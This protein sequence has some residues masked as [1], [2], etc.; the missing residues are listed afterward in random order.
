MERIT[1]RDKFLNFI[2]FVKKN[3]K[4]NNRV[5]DVSK[6]LPNGI[7]ARVI[8]LINNSTDNKFIID[9]VFIVSNNYN[10]Y[11]LT[12]DILG[13]DYYY[14][15]NYYL[16]ISEIKKGNKEYIKE[17]AK[18]NYPALVSNRQVFIFAMKILG[19]DY[20]YLRDYYDLAMYIRDFNYIEVIKYLE[21]FDPRD[22]DY[23]AYR[24]ALQYGN[25]KYIE[26]IEDEIIKRDWLEKQ[27]L[28]NMLGTHSPYKELHRNIRKL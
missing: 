11:K 14:L 18:T 27:A 28:E 2:N 21:K 12:T 7:G 17:I 20:E 13:P 23:F 5:V 8:S 3:A 9:N 15:A 24:I 6:I 10:S 25:N 4:D 16:I 22:N 1:D 19:S 26:L